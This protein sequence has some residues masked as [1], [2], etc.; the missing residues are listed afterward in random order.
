MALFLVGPEVWYIKPGIEVCA[1]VVHPADGKG[2]VHAEF[3]DLEVGTSEVGQRI[4]PHSWRSQ[5]VAVHCCG[6]DARKL[7][8][9]MKLFLLFA[10]RK[11]LDYMQSDSI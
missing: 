7:V 4:V 8:W 11:A 6:L 5:A 10:I 9:V 2:K 1:E 3:E